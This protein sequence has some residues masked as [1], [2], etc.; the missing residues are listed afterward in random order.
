MCTRAQAERRAP[1][2]RREHANSGTMWTSTVSGPRSALNARSN[3]SH[4]ANRA[5]PATDPDVGGVRCRTSTIASSATCSAGARDE[6]DRLRERGMVGSSACVTKTSLHQRRPQSRDRRARGTSGELGTLDASPRTLREPRRRDEPRAPGP[7]HP[8]IAATSAPH[9]PAV[10]GFRP[11]HRWRDRGCR[12]RRSLRPR[13]R[14]RRPR[15]RR[16]RAPRARRAGRAEL[17]H[18]WPARRRRARARRCARRAAAIREGVSRS[19]RGDPLPTITSRASGKS[20]ATR[21]QA[22]ASH[23]RSCRPRALRRR[24]QSA[25]AVATDRVRGERRKVAIGRK[26]S[27]GP[28]TSHLLDET[29]GEV[30]KRALRRPRWPA[31][32]ARRRARDRPPKRRAVEPRERPPVPVDLDDHGCTAAGERPPSRTAVPTKGSA[33]TITSGSNSCSASSL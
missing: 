11:P 4:G 18:P 25:V 16:G 14:G 32:Q 3:A 26:H 7:E 9:R 31:P 10:S 1:R 20:R 17:R 5:G 33:A 30:G 12:H 2:G 8:L 28:L 21:R 24:V 13:G 15:S 22:A 19:Q 23:R 29:R 27:V 6:I